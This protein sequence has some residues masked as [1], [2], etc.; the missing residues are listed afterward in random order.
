MDFMIEFKALA[1]K[2]DTDNLYTIFLLKKNVWADIIKTILE[3]PLIAAPDIL[4]EWK[5][6]ITTVEQG[7]ES[8]ESWYNYKTNTGITFG[9]RGAPIDIGKSRNN[10]DENRKPRCF[11]C[12]LYEYLAKEYRRS[13]REREIRKCYKCDKQGHLAK[14]CKSKE[15]MKN[16]RNQA[17]DSEEE[18]EK[19]FVEGLE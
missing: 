5:V 2:A 13:K 1:I 9:G 11:N 17:D 16:R 6:A 8:M 4:K 12:N 18:K 15:L 3:Y 10:F 7:Y 19:S 14:D